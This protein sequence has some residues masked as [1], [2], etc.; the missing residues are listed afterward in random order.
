MIV[1][2]ISMI[3][4]VGAGGQTVVVVLPIHRQ[5]KESAVKMEAGSERTA[6]CARAGIEQ[7]ICALGACALCDLLIIGITDQQ[8]C[9]QTD[10]AHTG[11]NTEHAALTVVSTGVAPGDTDLSIFCQPRGNAAINDVD[12]TANG[13]ATVEQGRRA[14][15]DL[16]A[17]SK[18]G[19]Y[20]Y[21]MV[22]TE[23]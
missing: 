21:R 15:Q 6:G 2:L 5:T 8:I 3:V 12:D 14:T 20:R 16:N 18:Q 11:I 17:V 23:R 22:G 10:I 1:V 13:A 19:F 4:A 7:L 9:V